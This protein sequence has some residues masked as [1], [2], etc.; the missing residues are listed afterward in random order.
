MD[1][2][3]PPP[4]INPSLRYSELLY[5]CRLNRCNTQGNPSGDFFL[6]N[7]LNRNMIGQHLTLNGTFYS[8]NQSFHIEEFKS[9]LRM[10]ITLIHD[11]LREEFLFYYAL[12]SNNFFNNLNLACEN[13]R[14][15]EKEKD[16]KRKWGYAKSMQEPIGVCNCR[17]A[18]NWL[19]FNL[20]CFRLVSWVGQFIQKEASVKYWRC[21]WVESVVFGQFIY[22]CVFQRENGIKGIL[23]WIFLV[24]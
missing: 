16:I 23:F 17:G 21:T 5:C 6:I 11:H 22:A 8:L 15:K 4:P 12:F 10:N 3:S 18:I 1:T 9:Q 13:E 2:D 7:S 19:S 24:W 14:R 20:S